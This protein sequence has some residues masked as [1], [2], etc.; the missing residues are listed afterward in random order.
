LLQSYRTY[1][2]FVLITQGQ[3]CGVDRVIVK[4]GIV[5]LLAMREFVGLI[6]EFD[7]RESANVLG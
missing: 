6:V 4:A 3:V 2:V 1:V 7:G 5:A